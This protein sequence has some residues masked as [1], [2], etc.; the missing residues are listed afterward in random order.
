MV[1]IKLIFIA[2]AAAA[3]WKYAHLWQ[4]GARFS[5]TKHI[6]SGTAPQMLRNVKPSKCS[7]RKPTI[8]ERLPNDGMRV[9]LGVDTS[10]RKL[11]V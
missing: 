10:S 6:I 5:Q 1:V 7:M 4:G 2:T 11:S 8:P 3:Y 9:G